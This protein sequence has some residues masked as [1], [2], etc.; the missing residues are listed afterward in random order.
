MISKIY[1]KHFRVSA[2][3][4]LGFTIRLAKITKPITKQSIP[5]LF[6]ISIAVCGL[7]ALFFAHATTSTGSVEAENGS[8]AGGSA[9]TVSDSTASGNKAVV[10]N[11]AASTSGN[12]TLS[13]TLVP[14]C[15]ALLGAWSGNQGVTGLRNSVEEHETRIGRQLDVVHSYHAP[16][17]DIL[18]TDEKYFVNRPN[19]ILLAN[20]KPS[21]NWAD[22]GGSNAS[23]NSQIDTFAASVGSVAPKKVIVIIYHEPENDVSGG[24][25]N[26]ASSVFKGNAGTPTD[27][28]AMWANVENRF[29][30]DGVTNVVWGFAFMNGDK[31]ECLENDM[32][33]GN[34]LVDWLFYEPYPVNGQSWTTGIGTFYNW[35]EANSNSAH[36][37]DSKPW[38]LGEWGAWQTTQGGT[39]GVYSLYANGSKAITA[40]TFPRLKM[41]VVFDDIGVDDSRVNHTNAS[42]LDTG[43]CPAPTKTDPNATK[44]CNVEQNFYNYFAN[45]PALCNYNTCMD[46]PTLPSSW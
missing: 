39:N 28:K 42:T 14:S 33:P 31:W 29:K 44:S 10:F 36:D 12:C 40:N 16:G 27:Y 23:V 32:W 25:S 38:G 35:L 45:T 9:A 34:G 5:L 20:F 26:C 43:T 17:N 11:K 4:T 18:S 21:A 15:G 3:R 6:V 13:A 19:T 22:A 7:A 24:D 2:A 30:A 8:V 1:H 37:Y 46:Q 41:Y